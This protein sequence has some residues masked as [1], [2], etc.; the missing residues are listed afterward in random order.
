MSSSDLKFEAIKLC[1]KTLIGLWVSLTQ[2]ISNESHATTSKACFLLPGA[3]WVLLLL[4]DGELRLHQFLDIA[5]PA[6]CSMKEHAGPSLP[7]TDFVAGPY[8]SAVGYYCLRFRSACVRARGRRRVLC[9]I[10]SLGAL[11]LLRGKSQCGAR[12][13]ALEAS[14]RS[15][16]N[17]TPHAPAPL[18]ARSLHDVAGARSCYRDAQSCRVSQR[19]RLHCRPGGDVAADNKTGLPPL[20]S[21]RCRPSDPAPPEY[22]WMGGTAPAAIGVG[23]SRTVERGVARGSDRAPGPVH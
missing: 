2:N 16:R 7:N 19:G 5:G 13:R 1:T 8:S 20:L 17:P 6:I 21:A 4:R 15:T 3:Q 18:V 23:R 9:R 10:P 12:P 11:G 22:P 14:S